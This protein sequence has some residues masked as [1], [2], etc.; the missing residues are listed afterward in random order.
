MSA[1]I[2]GNGVYRISAILPDGSKLKLVPSPNNEDLDLTGRP[3]ED[4]DKWVVNIVSTPSGGGSRTV[5]ITSFDGTRILSYQGED[6]QA[7]TLDSE[8]ITWEIESVTETGTAGLRISTNKKPGYYV[9]VIEED[10]IFSTKLVE[11][12]SQKDWRK[13]FTE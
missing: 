7:K 9:K 11:P 6:L 3:S 1:D 13:A 4:E 10:S 12:E 5:R 8:V 2:P